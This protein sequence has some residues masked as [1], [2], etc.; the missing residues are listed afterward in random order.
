MVE[1]I[2]IF[3]TQNLNPMDIEGL[4]ID[5]LDFMVSFGQT[6]N[7]KRF[8]NF[9]KFKNPDYFKNHL[10]VF[11]TTEDHFDE[12]KDIRAIVDSKFVNLRLKRNYEEEIQNLD[13]E[14]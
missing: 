7:V 9:L 2:N 10:T 12:I 4:I 6:N 13:E 11:T 5:N 1:V 8:M 3:R 14:E